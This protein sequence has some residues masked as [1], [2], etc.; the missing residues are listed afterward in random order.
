MIGSF[1]EFCFLF[2]HQFAS[3]RTHRKIELSLFSISQK[4]GEPLKEFLQHFN[5]A[6]LEVPSTTQ[7][8]KT[9]AFAQGLLDG[10][11]FTSLAKKPATKFGALLARATKYIN[12]EDA[13]TF[14]R[15]RRGEKRK[16][17]KD[18]GLPKNQ[19]QTLRTRSQHGKG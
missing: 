1:Q 4:E 17:N 5:M 19:R 11:F 2:L 14:K 7:E 18:E 9:S 13:H 16:E 3:S 8:V 15:E 12:M 6:A 10:D